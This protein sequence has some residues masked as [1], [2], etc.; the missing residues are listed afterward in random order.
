MRVSIVSKP[1]SI[2]NRKIEW[3]ILYGCFKKKKEKNHMK[4]LSFITQFEIEFLLQS[5]GCRKVLG[6]MP[7]LQIIS[8]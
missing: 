5:T 8:K 4:K 2:K 7:A 3:K 1:K 6:K